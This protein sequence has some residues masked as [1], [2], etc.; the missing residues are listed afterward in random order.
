GAIKTV[1]IAR[2]SAVAMLI[3]TTAG[4]MRDPD[5]RYD[6]RKIVFSMRKG[7]QDDYKI[8]EIG[9][10]GSNLRQLTFAQGVT[11]IDPFYLPDG[12]IVFSSTREP[13]YCMC[14]VHIMANLFRMD[15]DGANIHQLGK[16][17]LFEGHGA[18]MPDGRIVY[19]RWEYIDRNFGDAQSLWTCNPD[20]TNHVVYWG[21]NTASPGG[22]IEP[23]PIPGTLK[24]LC[25]LGSC[26][27]RPWGALAILDRERGMDGREPVVMTWPPDAVNLVTTKGDGQWDV[28][29]Q[30]K[31]KYEDP[32]PL[33]DKYFLCSRMTGRGE[34]MA[35][36]LVD[37]FGNEVLAHEEAPGCY[38][39]MPLAPRS[40]PPVIPDRREYDGADGRFY[41][42]DVYRGTHIQGVKQGAA[43]WL[44]VIES[45][46]KRFWTEPAWGGQGVHRPAMNWH[47]FSN[48]RILG[49]V[50][51]ET[52]GSA[53]FAVPSG[54][55]VYFQLLDANG[56]MIQSMRSGTMVQPGESQGCIGCHDE[57]RTAPPLPIAMSDASDPSDRSEKA[58]P[59][60]LAL[61][62]PASA[63][64]GWHG[65]PREFSYLTEVQPVFDK[66]CLSCHDFGKE[67]GKK[68]ILAGDRDLT[69]NASYEELWRKKTIAAIGAG[70]AQIQPAYSWGSHP[71]LL[72]K[73]LREG[74]KGVKLDPES[75]D[76]LVTWI[77]VN[78]P[79]YP[80]YD[81]A[82]PNN[83]AGR[84]PLESSQIQR[85]TELTGIPFAKQATHNS[86]PGP[87]ISFDRPSLSPCLSKFESKSDPKYLEALAIIQSG[88]KALADR[89]RGERTAQEDFQACEVD[90]RRQHKYDD[91]QRAELRNLEAIRQGR[92]VFDEK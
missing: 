91:R 58:N 2:G 28:F 64:K 24:M 67:G 65:A 36:Y 92:K 42:M 23:R 49:T 47:D 7:I 26:H 89:P 43:K 53:Y 3:E 37:V 9:A 57:R 30:V 61:K 35:I 31:L 40:R 46:E 22:V 12:S 39:P 15:A 71:S 60:P 19:D 85:L 66:Y 1:D 77:D 56:M 11:D 88:G 10:D 55:F 17:T 41:V 38:D 6:G 45:P 86:N 72:I 18:T 20:G 8:Y 52:D 27:D 44:R 13:K 78:A 51:V 87:Q 70:P 59:I 68:L 25:V 33:N 62:R 29:K 4:L 83:L 80:R 50:P 5:V 21:N 82:Y 14:N 34:E 74:H 54:K 73:K 84:A 63:M 75:F 32:Y 79:Y 81:T 90:Q 69:F 76:R 48:K 16:N